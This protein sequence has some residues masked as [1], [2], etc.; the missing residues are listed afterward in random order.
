[1][2]RLWA[3]ERAFGDTV[4]RRCEG[5]MRQRLRMPQDRYR[6]GFYAVLD[7]LEEGKVEVQMQAVRLGWLLGASLH[8]FRMAVLDG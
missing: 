8:L 6:N 3:G 4:A 7:G 2:H 1:M 5:D